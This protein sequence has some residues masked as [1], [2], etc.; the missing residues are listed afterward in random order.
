MDIKIGE[1][2]EPMTDDEIYLYIMTK[3]AD[4]KEQN[5]RIERE[6]MEKQRMY[7]LEHKASNSEVSAVVVA[8]VFII[9]LVMCIF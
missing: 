4:A 8:I 2:K 6:Q 3:F 5:A 1:Q 7:Q 9:A